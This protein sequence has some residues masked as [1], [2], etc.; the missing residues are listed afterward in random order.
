MTSLK[1]SPSTLPFSAP[2]TV[3]I[4]TVWLDAAGHLLERRP[5]ECTRRVQ[6]LGGGVDL[7]LVAVPGGF[8]SMG[9]HNEG[10]YADEGPLHPV[11]IEKFWLG[12]FPVTQAQWRAVM[13]SLPPCRFHGDDWPVETI[14]WNEAVE[15]CQR[16][17][18]LTGRPYTLPSEAQWEYACRAGTSTPFNLGETITTDY[19]NYVGDHTYRQAPVGVYRHGPTPVGSFPPNR[20]GLYDMHGEVWEFCADRWTD[21]YQGASVN[22]LVPV[23]TFTRPRSTIF[24]RIATVLGSTFAEPSV[25]HARSET[26]RVARG[27]SWHETPA[28]C[29]SAVRLKVEEHERLEFYGLRV[30]LPWKESLAV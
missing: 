27:G 11:L 29:R 17:A 28:H 6:A 1:D 10:G 14:C 2:Q 9:S 3:P 7:N 20:W 16:L 19:V 5:G 22:G 30:L 25:P 15:F 26:Y 18:L 23:P 8:F 4:E 21:D 12:Q 24:D 13:G